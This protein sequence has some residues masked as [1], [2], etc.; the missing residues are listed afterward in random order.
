[1]TEECSPLPMGVVQSCKFIFAGQVKKTAPSI[2]HAL[3]VPLHDLIFHIMQSLTLWDE[4]EQA[5]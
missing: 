1:M 5:R 3:T 2:G 4:S